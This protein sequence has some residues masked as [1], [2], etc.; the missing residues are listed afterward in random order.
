VGRVAVRRALAPGRDGP[1][2]RQVRAALSGLH[3]RMAVALAGGD[4]LAAAA[5]HLRAAV[6]QDPANQ[7]AREQLRQLVA[8]V[9]EAYL[10][11]YMAKDGDAD[12]ARQA[13]RL[14]VAALPATDDTALKARRWLDRLDGKPA[15][16]LEE[17][18]ASPATGGAR[19]RGAL[20]EEPASPAGPR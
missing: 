20:E 2:A 3:T 1:L 11:G 17:E 19:R 4:D 5:A 18:P 16:A 13:F 15:G 6:A 12:A 10:R 14:V 8:R 9:E 7:G